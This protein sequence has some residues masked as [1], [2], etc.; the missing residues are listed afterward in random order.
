MISI[1]KK[2]YLGGMKSNTID[3]SSTAAN[4]MRAE[5]KL[6]T[7]RI[8]TILNR[9]ASSDIHHSD[10]PNSYKPCADRN[11][12]VPG[13][14]TSCVSS[15]S[16]C[17]HGPLASAGNVLSS[18]ILLCAIYA[19]IGPCGILGSSGTRGW[20][21]SF[22]RAWCKACLQQEE[23]TTTK[24]KQAMFILVSDAPI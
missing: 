9:L 13:L 12:I 3:G 8:R 18:C 2:T 1:K 15:Q 14:L 23:K 11:K 16:S 19:F 6:L 4:I 5:K 22:P 21:L 10:F 17:L 24:I 7:Y 20:K